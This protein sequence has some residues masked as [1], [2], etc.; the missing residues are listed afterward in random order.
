MN[1]TN[2]EVRMLADDIM[3]YVAERYEKKFKDI[4]ID[5]KKELEKQQNEILIANQRIMNRIVREM[6]STKTPTKP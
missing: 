5:F 6:T 4:K 2:R 1:T 3:N